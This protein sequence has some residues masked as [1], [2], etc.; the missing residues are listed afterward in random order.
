MAEGVV[1]W[2]RKRREDT[3]DGKK[4]WETIKN[5]ILGR[6]HEG[7][8]HDLGSFAEIL[9]EVLEECDDLKRIPSDTRLPICSLYHHLKSTAG[10][11]VCLGIDRGYD[12]SMLIKLRA[13]GK[14]LEHVRGGR[15]RSM[16]F[17]Q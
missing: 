2:F 12:E 17:Y 8:Y 3:E 9:S 11:A 13:P 15:G 1:N 10:I 6:Q 14:G 7:R 5:N 4:I 16:N